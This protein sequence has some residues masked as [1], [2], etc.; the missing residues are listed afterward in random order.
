MKIDHQQIAKNL[1]HAETKGRAMRRFTAS[2]P[3]FSIADGYRVQTLL[4]GLHEAAGARVSGRKM[5]MTSLAKMQQMGINSPIQ[6][7]LTD[8]M[9]V[10]NGGTLAL[11]R[12]I[13][14]KAEPEI[15]FVLGRELRGKVSE[16]EALAAVSGVAGAIEVI[17]SR[18]ENFDFGL[19]DVVADNCSSSAFVLGPVLKNFQG[20]DLA[21][22]GISFEQNG[23]AVQSGSSSAILGNPI[24]SLTALVELLAQNGEALPA[25][26]VVL[27]GAATA[28]MAIKKGDHVRAT[29]SGLGK[30][31]FTVSGD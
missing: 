15:A 22:I 4:R 19:P 13:H 26:S 21:A 27:A 10:A 28:A 30:A 5:G 2:L 20:V 23:K 17:D 16:S 14:P 6:G 12:R 11:G 18:Y 3:D 24:R 25:G 31:E 1:F 9:Q 8:R 7:F 29:F